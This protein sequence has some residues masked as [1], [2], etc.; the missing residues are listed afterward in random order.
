M[1]HD[2]AL[3]QRPWELTWTADKGFGI[4]SS[5]TSHDAVVNDEWYEQ[6]TA[7]PEWPLF[8]G[9]LLE[10]WSHWGDLNEL[11]ARFIDALSWHSDAISERDLSARIV[12]FWTAIERLLSVSAK[13]NLAARLTV[14]ATETVDRFE[15]CAQRFSILYQR[16][17][18][19]VHGNASR[20]REGWYRQAAAGAEEASKTALIQF[21]RAIP[22]IRCRHRASDRKSLL[23][24]LSELDEMAD[25]F[26]KEGAKK[27]RDDGST[28]ADS[29]NE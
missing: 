11:L 14:L 19:I 17:S 9:A 2:I 5:G 22:Y 7:W 27:R 24:W 16:R 4:R 25:R 1:A 15:A 29:R 26:R 18:D 6:V 20:T 12:K 28:D 21:L 23:A 10:Y 8:E 13:G 3:P